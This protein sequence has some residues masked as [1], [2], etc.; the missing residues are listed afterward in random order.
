LFHFHDGKL[1]EPLRYKGV[2][3]TFRAQVGFFKSR[4]PESVQFVQVG[5]YLEAYDGDARL[6]HRLTGIALKEGFRR[7][8]LAAGFPLRLENRFVAAV[9]REGRSVVLVR[10]AGPG[11]YVKERNARK[12][13][14]AMEK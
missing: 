2:F 14:Y 3:R 11:K 12:L 4:F 7:M 5:A 8:G 13:L 1:A 6:L 9:L 10:E